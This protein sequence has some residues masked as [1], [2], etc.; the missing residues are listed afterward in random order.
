MSDGV[1]LHTRFFKK[2][3]STQARISDSDC[4]FIILPPPPPLYNVFSFLGHLFRC[5]YVYTAQ[6][7]QIWLL[8]GSQLSLSLSDVAMI[9]CM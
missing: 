4:F 9:L 5:I 7:V 2:Q 8:D 6:P 3:A 1:L